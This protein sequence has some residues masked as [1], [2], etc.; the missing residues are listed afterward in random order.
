MSWEP[1]IP[2][3]SSRCVLPADSVG[4][5]AGHYLLVHVADCRRLAIRNHAVLLIDQIGRKLAL[6]APRED[7]E[8]R[9]ELKAKTKGGK[10]RDVVRISCGGALARMGLVK[11]AASLT[12]ERIVKD[13]M[14]V[15]LF[16]GSIAQA[17]AAP[18]LQRRV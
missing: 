17:A 8:Y 2:K 10:L 7:D 14:L 1:Y 11:G 12:L 4:V 6:R 13:D 16:P 18:K 3:Q 15:I 9:V 5:R